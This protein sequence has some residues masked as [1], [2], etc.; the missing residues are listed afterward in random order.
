MKIPR[1]VLL[2]LVI[3]IVLLLRTVGS[4]G[5]AC[6]SLLKFAA[7]NT[8]ITLAEQ[9]PAG[10]FKA[11]GGAA[12]AQNASR[13]AQLPA[14]CRVAA[15][16]NPT[17]DSDIKI[18]VWMPASGW[19][20][21]FE[22]VGNG[23]WAGTISYPAMAQA[24]AR[25]YATTSTDTGHSTPGA[26]FAFGHPEKLIDYAYRSEHETTVKAKAIISAFYGNAPTRS[27]FNGC[28][29]GGRQAL[30][31]AS[32]FP[33]DFDGIIAGAAANP[34][35]RLDTW[36]IW[37]GLETMKD[38]ATRIPQEKYPAIHQAVLAAC[39]GL[40][41]LKDGLIDDP[42]RCH[43]DAHVLACKDGDGPSCLTPK[44]VQS[45]NT[46]LG[47]AK[48]PRTG[49][50]IFPGYQPGT[51]LQWGRLIGGSQ[52]YE[53]ALDQFRM[54]F[55]DAKWD[56]RTFDVDRDLAKAEESLKGLLT[57]IDPA[58]IGAFL[59]RGGK[60]LTYHGWSDQEHRAARE[61]ELL[62][63]RGE[64]GR[65]RDGVELAPTVH[66]A[67]HGTL[68]RRRRTQYLRHDGAAGAVGRDGTGADAGRRI[69]QHQRHSRSHASTVS[70][71]AGGA[72]HGHRKHGRSRELHLPATV[73]VAV[74][75]LI[76][77]VVPK[78]LDA[79]ERRSRI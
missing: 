2:A 43:F 40:D 64:R 65:R 70:V 46:V 34:K 9:V 28:S 69:A 31:E 4:A 6:E 18:E 60:L 47:P 20:G 62:Q 39:D 27:Y 11:P 24:L 68:R 55:N 63:E 38:P 37:M 15:T 73:M 74:S 26:S 35:T 59:E 44:Q 45:V 33:D 50:E 3:A 14:F 52:P 5:S 19:N 22:A 58:S 66:G 57:A 48:S 78:G 75:P 13:F 30:I 49:A 54:V 76:S 56:W 23:G 53:T 29:T 25:G 41:G 21:K 32:R 7:E 77:I 51:E 1:A 8:T 12:G 61:R 67:W 16:L 42:T 36:R 10:G 17:A 72:L 79:L 71:S